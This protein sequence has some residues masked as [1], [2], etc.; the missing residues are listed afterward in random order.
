MFTVYALDLTWWSN[1]WHTHTHTWIHDA[2]LSTFYS[3]FVWLYILVFDFVFCH[4]TSLPT[5]WHL[6]RES[7][8]CLSLYFLILNFRSI[9]KR[10]FS[11]GNIL[12]QS[13]SPMSATND[14][15]EK[16][17]NSTLPDRSQGGNNGLSESSPE[18]STCESDISYSRFPC[19]PCSLLHVLYFEVSFV[20]NWWPYLSILHKL[21]ETNG[22]SCSIHM[23]FLIFNL[24]VWLSYSF[25]S[26]LSWIE[27]CLNIALCIRC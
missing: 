14:K 15:Q 12:R 6:G 18:I 24:H 21:L 13:G 22:I 2:D 5:F 25:V 4:L 1:V 19:F 23:D 10:S 20:S 7:H 9:F 11:D 8:C 26:M 3:S 16:F 17:T 27:F